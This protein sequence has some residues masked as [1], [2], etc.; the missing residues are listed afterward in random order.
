MSS[1]HLPENTHYRDDVLLQR[2]NSRY[3]EVPNG[4]WIWKGAKNDKGYGQIYVPGQGL[5]YA[6]RLAYQ[7]YRGEIP[8]G[9]LVC[10]NCPAGDNPS[11]VNPHHLFLGTVGDNNRD[12]FAKG[13]A[14]PTP[15]RG[16]AHTLAKLSPDQVVDLRRRYD[17]GETTI[18]LAQRFGIRQ[19]TAWRAARRL[20]YQGVA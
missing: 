10:H 6:H 19:S 13:R 20:S 18:A 3:V 2:F 17:A 9:M 7:W 16:S 12:M 5:K 14:R 8:D 11:C 4:C 1:D 15:T